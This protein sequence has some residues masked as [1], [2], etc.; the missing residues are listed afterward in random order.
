MVVRKNLCD[1]TTEM[2]SRD[3]YTATS[4]KLPSRRGE[5][6][7]VLYPDHFPEEGQLN[8]THTKVSK[9]SAVF[10]CINSHRDA[11]LDK[12]EPQSNLINP[13]QT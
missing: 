6:K 4:I 8:Y 12:Q 3:R 2:K 5:S 1:I 10:L 9:V 13:G 7:G 11:K